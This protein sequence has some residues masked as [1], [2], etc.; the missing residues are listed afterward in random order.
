MDSVI[1]FQSKEA[2][3]LKESVLAVLPM[4]RAVSGGYTCVRF[5]DS[6]KPVSADISLNADDISADSVK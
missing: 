6:D 1:D 4:L 5:T 2:N 3:D